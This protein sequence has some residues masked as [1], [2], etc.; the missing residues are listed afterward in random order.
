MPAP[1]TSSSLRNR[2]CDR[3]HDHQYNEDF[4]PCPVPPAVLGQGAVPSSG[5]VMSGAQVAC[6]GVEDSAANRSSG[7]VGQLFCVKGPMMFPAEPDHCQWLAVV[8]VMPFR[9]SPANNARFTR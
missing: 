4:C 2:L 6:H 5:L 1:R 3:N 7:Y 8:K 9:R